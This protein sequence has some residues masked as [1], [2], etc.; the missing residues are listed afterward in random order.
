MK[1]ED[2]LEEVKKTIKEKNNY[3]NATINLMA[4]L[5]QIDPIQGEVIRLL[6]G[7]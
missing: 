4:F 6:E 7:C 3:K 2:L 5:N 1:K